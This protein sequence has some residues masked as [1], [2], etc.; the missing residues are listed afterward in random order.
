MKKLLLSLMAA[1]FA[2]TSFA[3]HGMD[4]CFQQGGVLLYGI[5]SFS[6]THGS[7]TSSFS[8]ANATTIDQPRMLNWEVSPGLGF[9]IADNLTIGVDF[10]Y[11]GSKTNYDRKGI[12][13]AGNG[14]GTDQT[15]SFAYAVGPFV[16]YS[17]PI[18]E[19][20]FWYGQLEAHYLRN[21]FTTRS[22]NLSGSNSFVKDDNGK[23][24]DASYMPA[25]GVK[26]CKDMAITFGIGGISY[27]YMKY[28]FSTQ[29]LPAGSE[30]TGKTNEFNVSFGH[31]INIGVQKYFNC[32]GG[33]RMHGSEPM[34]ETRHIDTSDDSDDSSDTSK[35]RRRNR[36]NDDE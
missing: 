4:K 29:G 33:R 15:K 12:V 16:R 27:E 9:N 7:R 1:G 2:A 6:N 26:V 24:V 13:F 3:Q 34:D 22:T 20:F 31:Q 14:Y 35:K 17:M 18:G 8:N 25:V 32:G 11:T 10:N 28:D 5:G 21:R 36:K 23:G 19:H 30:L